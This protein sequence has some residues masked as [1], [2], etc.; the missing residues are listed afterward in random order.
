MGD[1]CMQCDFALCIYHENHACLL[2]G[3]QIN[4]LGMCEECIVVSIPDANL[5]ELKQDQRERIEKRK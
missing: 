1:V 2:Q 4:A 5:Q 3:T